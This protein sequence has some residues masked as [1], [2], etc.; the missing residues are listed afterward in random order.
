MNQ[1]DIQITKAQIASFSV[2][3]QENKP[4]ITATITLLTEGGQPITNYTISTNHWQKNNQF[5]LPINM[6]PPIL[7]IMEELEYIVVKH[8]K[9][10]QKQL[11]E[12]S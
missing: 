12:G 9:E 10:Q 2:E 1:L 6:I 5:E 7:K 8:C 4:N 3:L 11:V